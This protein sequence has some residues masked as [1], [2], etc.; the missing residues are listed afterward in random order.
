MR[1]SRARLPASTFFP[2]RPREPNHWIL[3]HDQ[4]QK[5]RD[6][7]SRS[8]PSALL[9]ICSRRRPNA[10]P[11]ITDDWQ[12]CAYLSV[13]NWRTYSFSPSF[14]AFLATYYLS[15]DRDTSITLVNIKV[16]TAVSKL[17]LWPSPPDGFAR[18]TRCQL[19]SND[20]SFSRTFKRRRGYLIGLV[21]WT[22][23]RAG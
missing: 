1:S 11:F 9:L 6:R 7:T 5:T 23:T 20:E 2:R 16:C 13:E 8:T 22:H 18:F 17:F 3:T 15:I 19:S 10:I 4:D 21:V 14:A 12:A